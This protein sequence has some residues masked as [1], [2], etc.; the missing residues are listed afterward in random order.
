MEGTANLALELD[1]GPQTEVGFS[2]KEQ[3]AATCFR[4]LF[5]HFYDG[6]LIIAFKAAFNTETISEVKSLKGLKCIQNRFIMPKQIN[7]ND[8]ISKGYDELVK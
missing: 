1:Q 4:N 6:K 8:Y 2:S 5:G 3:S 7:Y